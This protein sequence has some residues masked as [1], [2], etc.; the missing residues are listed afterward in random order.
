MELATNTLN[1]QGDS[2][3]EEV[4]KGAVR[5]NVRKGKGV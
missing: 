4:V 5:E 1:V 2:D 3:V